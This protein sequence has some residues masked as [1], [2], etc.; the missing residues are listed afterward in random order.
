MRGRLTIAAVMLLAGAAPAPGQ[1]LRSVVVPADAPLA[2]PPRGQSMP[3]P[4]RLPPAA[5]PTPMAAPGV[6]AAAPLAAAPM[7]LAAVPGLMLPLAAGVLFGGALA[8][9]GGSGTGAPAGTTG[10]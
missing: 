3:T 9:G 6:V 2:V 5:A 7:G 8:G 4:P 10:R 1:T